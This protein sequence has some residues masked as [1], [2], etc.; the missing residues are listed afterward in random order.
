MTATMARKEEE[1]MIEEAE[2]VTTRENRGDYTRH[3]QSTYD[4]RSGRQVLPKSTTSIRQWGFGHETRA[5]T[6]S[7]VLG[8]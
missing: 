1:Y 6:R 3:R 5:G 8:Y 4:A 7:F 2:N